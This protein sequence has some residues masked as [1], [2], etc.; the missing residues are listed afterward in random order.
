MLHQLFF[1]RCAFARNRLSVRQVEFV[2]T[3]QNMYLDSE[4]RHRLLLVFSDVGVSDFA[5]IENVYRAG[6][7]DAAF[8]VTIQDQ[9][10]IFINAHPK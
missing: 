3:A 10:S 8:S 5:S 9:S 2:S 6:A 1:R 7:D 4:N